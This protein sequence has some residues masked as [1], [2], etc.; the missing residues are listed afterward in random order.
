MNQIHENMDQ[1][2]G[3]P[4]FTTPKITAAEENNNKIKRE[5]KEIEKKNEFTV[6]FQIIKSI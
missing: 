1:V 4:I 3:P 2:H 6:I 5:R